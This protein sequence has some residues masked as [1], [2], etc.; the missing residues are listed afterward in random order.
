MAGVLCLGLLTAC[1]SRVDGSTIAAE[2]GGGTVRLTQ[3]SLDALKAAL[4]PAP[5]P[6][7]QLSA[8]VAAP[9][10]V[11]PAA[12]TAAAPAANTSPRK[13]TTSAAAPAPGQAVP[14]TSER[15]TGA[16][17]PSCSRSL[18]PI[19]LGHVG[20]FSGVAGPL[21]A[22]AVTTM[23]AWAKDVNARGGLACHPVKVFT[24]DDGAD[25]AKAAALANELVRREGVVAFLGTLAL[26]PAGFVQ[27]VE[28]LKVPAVGGGV[29]QDSWYTSP[30]L[31]ADS[32]SADDLIAGL[33][34]AGADKGKKKLGLLYCVEAPACGQVTKKV[35]GGAAKRA[36]VELVYDSAVSVTQPDY[37]AQC[38][39]A[40]KAGVDLLGL[41][42]DGASMTR[43]ARSC[44][45]IGFKPLLTTA[46]FLI[47][48]AQAAD[49][50]LRSFG[51]V[52]AAGSAPW[53][54][55][56]RPGLTEYQR[57]LARWAPNVVADGA[58]ISTWTSAK[59]FE[60][61][62]ANVAAKARSGA[63]TTALVVEGLGAVKG[64]TLDGLA[65]PIDFTSAAKRRSGNGCVFFQYLGAE[66]WTAPRGSKPV[67]LAP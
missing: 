67:C 8:D 46:S 48:T 60:A 53:F 64:D 54:L 43:V 1:G 16:A 25:P 11:A 56:D 26:Q 32:A 63:V 6:S 13:A 44:A 40:Q 45:S 27:A 21:T 34:K 57:A 31:Y 4:A 36:G 61:A 38:L 51:V 58:S 9:G 47:G 50:T 49:P 62:I 24:R 28:K 12:P 39:N 29:G 59:L 19:P 18:E 2:S 55:K 23:A 5:G 22:S 15:G 7:Q 20:T 66:G 52:T 3:E 10:E 42:V 41:A 33:L 17:A 30:W 37:T 14:P 35:Q 65:G